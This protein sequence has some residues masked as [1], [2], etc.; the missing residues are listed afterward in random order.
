MNSISFKI[1]DK[2]ID[3]LRFFNKTGNTIVI[4][5]DKE[6]NIIGVVSDGDI[7]R[8]LYEKNYQVGDELAN[9]I[10]YSPV[11]LDEN[12]NTDEILRLMRDKGI[13]QVPL[14]QNRKCI[15]ILN[16]DDLIAQVKIN[17]KKNTH[18]LIMAGG[19]GKRMRPLTENKPKPMLK[20]KGKP[21]L[22]HI[23]ANAKTF[24][25]NNITISLGYLGDQIVSYFGDGR[26]L[27]VNL[28][29]I[30][31]DEPMGT[32]GALSLLPS[33]KNK[34]LIVIN[35]DVL[36]A[37][38]FDHLL[39]YHNTF[40]AQ[41]TVVIKKHF[42]QNPYG[43]VLFDSSETL[44][45]FTEKPLYESWINAGIYVLEPATYEKLPTTPLDMPDLLLQINKKSDVRVYKFSNDWLDVGRPTD[46]VLANEKYST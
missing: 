38:D 3:V 39:S 11:V 7:R 44:I 24:G 31:E 28:Q 30:R 22:E 40:G 5:T 14:L 20:V 35:G 2:I 19:L 21:L 1:K 33:P 17:E 29:Y 15:K 34:Q 12:S 42:I 4:I 26:A 8:G 13:D 45:E 18:L 32:A 10:N 16:R 43:T 41:A 46:L 6:D 37:I 25:I 36:A 23:I 9:I 27:G